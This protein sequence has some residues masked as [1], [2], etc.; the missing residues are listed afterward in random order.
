[1]HNICFV[2]SYVD[3]LMAENLINRINAHK[4]LTDK[5]H[6]LVYE[7]SYLEYIETYCQNNQVNFLKILKSELDTNITI[8]NL[9]FIISWA[10][11]H[12]LKEFHFDQINF[13]DLSGIGYHCI[14]AKKMGIS[15][16]QT[17][18]NIEMFG[19]SQYRNEISEEWGY[20]GFEQLMTQYM[21]RYCCEFCDKL[22]SPTSALINWG[23]SR[24]WNLSENR[25]ILH[26]Y[27]VD[28]IDIEYECNVD[29]KC[30][31]YCGNLGKDGGLH[32][33]INS[34]KRIEIEGKHENIRKIIFVGEYKLINNIPANEYIEN[35]LGKSKYLFEIAG[36]NS[37]EQVIEI[38]ASNNGILVFPP[39]SSINGQ[40]IITASR[41]NISMIVS[42]NEAHREI[43]DKDSLF[44]LTPSGLI[45]AIVNNKFA[46]KKVEESIE[47]YRIINSK[48]KTCNENE[49]PL[50]T[51]CTAYYNH[52]RFIE[53]ARKSI[54][55][56]DYPNI[57]WIVI[58][59]GSTDK[60]SIEILDKYRVKYKDKPYKFLRKENEGPS[61]ARNYGS[62][63]ANG[64]LLIFMDSDNVAKPDMV[65]K[66]VQA[67]NNSSCDCLSCYFD[68]FN[69]EGEVDNKSL[70]GITYSLLGPSLETGVFN[71]C[72]G[73]TN[74]IVKKSVFENV[75]GFLPQRVVTEDWQILAN[76]ALSGYKIDV[77]PEALFWY[78]V[79]PE[80]NV[81]Y[82]SEY[83]K[84]QIIMRTYCDNLPPYV[85][86]VFNSLCRPS[87]SVNESLSMTRTGAFYLKLVE[88]AGNIFPLGSRRRHI[89]KMI[90]DRFI[91]G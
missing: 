1:M 56:Q 33:F 86:H 2:V 11:Y 66:F 14:Q 77:I 52:G 22:I 3:F 38:V 24:K 10:T 68:Q 45:H 47:K 32:L 91:K 9:P 67:M 4:T 39:A 63:N 34:L 29:S 83:Y 30:L 75:G 58:D 61:I 18:L 8:Q 54:E 6:L 87:L 13:V 71:N 31:V 43:F 90:I 36:A 15:F 5:I 19:A 48:Q 62:R 16:Q 23:L 27:P 60:E 69:G 59:D 37:T 89:L 84:Q 70:N 49:I 51:I 35:N 82:G 73:D 40:D 28:F 88:L 42:D 78:R 64:D 26:F 74:F 72:F 50:V 21:E 53:M 17:A 57:E 65:S 81:G 41:N 76:I 20:G 7:G 79:L 46:E 80:S 44:T 55:L 12:K 85:Y 25:E